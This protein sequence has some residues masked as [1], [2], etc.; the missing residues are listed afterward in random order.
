MVETVRNYLLICE[1]YNNEGKERRNSVA[2]IIPVDVAH[3]DGF[4]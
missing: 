4:M 3:A 2:N 1:G